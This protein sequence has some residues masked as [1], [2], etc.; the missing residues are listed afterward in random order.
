MSE[1]SAWGPHDEVVGGM[2]RAQ[3]GGH[4]VVKEDP[5]HK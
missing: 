5:P 2:M 3:F 1:T 4:A